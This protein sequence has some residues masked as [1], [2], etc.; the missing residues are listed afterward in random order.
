MMEVFRPLFVVITVLGLI[1]S[2][3]TGFSVTEKHNVKAQIKEMFLHG[4]IS[5]KENAFPADELMP[6]SCKGRARNV[7]TS[8]GDVDDALGNFSLTMIDTLD[9]LFLFDELDEFE[10]AVRAVVDS[11]SFDSDIEVSV[12]ETNIRILGGLLGAHISSLEVQK[13][14]HSRMKWYSDELLQM[15]IDIGNRLIPAFNTSTGIPL[16][17]VNLRYGCEKLKRKEIHTCTACGGTMILEFAALSRLTGNPIYEDKAARAMAALWKQRNRH[18]DLMGRVINVHSGDWVRRE[19]GIGAGIDSYYEYLLKAFVLLGEPVY[20]HRFHTHYEA[21]KRYV[22][23]PQ[24]AAFPFLFLDVH[25]HRPSERARSFMDV[26]LSF[27][28]GLQVLVGD[29]KP[30]VALHEFLFQVYKRNKLLPEAFT[31]DLRVH[32]GE[33]LLRPEFVESTYLLYRATNDP[34]Y[35]DVGAQI[36]ADMQR[37]ARVPCGFAA[38]EDVRT[39][40]HVDRFDS[41]VL[42]ETFKY[43]YLLFSEPSDLPISLSEYVFTTEAHLLPISLSQLRRSESPPEHSEYSETG[44]TDDTLDPS[45][46]AR[47]VTV[48]LPVDHHGDRD[49]VAETKLHHEGQCPAIHFGPSPLSLSDE[50]KAPSRYFS[51]KLGWTQTG[52]MCRAIDGPHWYVNTM[53]LKNLT[54]QSASVHSVSPDAARKR[55]WRSIDLI[56]QPLRQMAIRLSESVEQLT[57]S[58]TNHLPQTTSGFVPLRAIDFRPDNPAHLAIL[59]H[60]GIELSMESDGRLT[61]KQDQNAADSAQ[62]SIAGLL[63][64]HDLLSLSKAQQQVEEIPVQRRHVVLIDP[65]NFGR[66]RFVACPAYFGLF[67]GEQPAGR[68]SLQQ[69]DGPTSFDDSPSSSSS[70]SSSFTTTNTSSNDSE[71]GGLSERTSS[72]SSW[73]PLI[74]AIRI[75]HPLDGCS[76]ISP[77]GA[78]YPSGSLDWN[79]K[80]DSSDVTESSVFDSSDPKTVASLG[81]LTGSIGIIRRGSCLFIQKARNLARAGAIG[82]IVVDNDG[83]SSAARSLL[84]TMSGEEDPTK[85]D[86]NIPFVLLFGAERDRLLHAMRTHWERTREPLTVMLTKDYNPTVVFSEAMKRLSVDKESFLPVPQFQFVSEV[87]IPTAKTSVVGLRLPSLT[88]GG[89]SVSRLAGVEPSCTAQY[90]HAGSHVCPPQHFETVEI[91]WAVTLFVESE[92]LV[93]FVTQSPDGSRSY[94]HRIELWIAA[95][96]HTIIHS[97]LSVQCRGILLAICEAALHNSSLAGGTYTIHPTIHLLVS[98]VNFVDRCF[99]RL[100]DRARF[101]S[102]FSVG[103]KWSALNDPKFRRVSLILG[104]QPVLTTFNEHPISMSQSS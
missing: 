65:P 40:K 79:A 57:S 68:E 11:V 44:T 73:R 101:L 25:M 91:R 77:Q 28:P 85:N 37:Y 6:L 97:K 74:S 55:I 14:N 42:A 100:N 80:S 5:Y 26:L 3:A 93:D 30:A 76:E 95:L 48:E 43:L 94:P 50:C 29:V 41:F 20:L 84:F 103:P 36:V 9:T 31:P 4:Y 2:S 52:S 7:E 96:N 33:H 87:D 13:A 88:R 51:S 59:R 38:I 10:H 21:I 54:K 98:W 62:L 56:R 8:R 83:T 86:V 46:Q 90:V 99:T 92:E 71:A 16:P 58:A 89:L 24:S 12:F 23:G 22:S 104:F 27:W 47:T 64:I 17:R 82:G 67:P 60:M 1:F 15:A 66:V 39:M 49:H 78:A 63:F 61:L 19:S 18:S 81:P 70:S 34:Y 75:V 45:I 69:R 35:L 53:L 102:A 32:W 72:R